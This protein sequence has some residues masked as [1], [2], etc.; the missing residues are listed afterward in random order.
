M[1]F[2]GSM[3]SGGYIVNPPTDVSSFCGFSMQEEK[4]AFAAWSSALAYAA[5]RAARNLGVS[6]GTCGKCTGNHHV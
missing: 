3:F 2:W 6:W 5:D 4:A 1:F